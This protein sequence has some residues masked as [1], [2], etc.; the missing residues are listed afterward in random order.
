MY[1]R[2]MHVLMYRIHTFLDAGF[3]LLVGLLEDVGFA[4]AA[5]A[6]LAFVV[7]ALAFG[8]VAAFLGFD[9]PVTACQYHVNRHAKPS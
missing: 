3:A 4:L 5:G 1:V 7:A 8:F 2:I 9:S 6:L